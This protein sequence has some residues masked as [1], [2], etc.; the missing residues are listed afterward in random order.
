MLADPAAQ[1]RLLDLQAEDTAIAQLEHRRKSLPEHATLAEARVVRGRLG[2]SLIAARTTVGDLQLDVEKAESDLVPVRERQARDQQR[3]DA[4]TVTDPKQLNALLDE[5]THLG[6]RISDLEDVELE[7]ME[8]LES[9]TAEQDRLAAELAD[10]ETSMRAQIASRDEQV[11]AIDAEQATHQAS[12]D[13]IAA[14][15]P[16]DLLALYDRIRPRA[17]GV[18]AAAL[19]GRRCGGCQLEATQSALVAYAA[20]APNEVLRCEECERILVRTSAVEA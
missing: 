19:K 2:E 11:A 1:L 10:L 13:G 9:A 8:Q 4:G 14:G 16:A 20:A 3:V 17:G 12:R 7:V 18:G 5:I 15:I 6:R